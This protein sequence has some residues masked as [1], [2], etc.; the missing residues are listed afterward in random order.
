[1]DSKIIL[2]FAV[3]ACLFFAGCAQQGISPQGPS[4]GNDSGAI[5]T[6]EPGAQPVPGGQPPG[7]EPGT[8]PG[9]LPPINQSPG[10]PFPGP[11]QQMNQSACPPPPAPCLP[12][13]QSPGQPFPGPGQPPNPSPGQQ[14]PSSNTLSPD[15]STPAKGPV[16]QGQ[17]KTFRLGSLQFDYYSVAATY[18]I[19]SP[20]V[21]IIIRAKNTGQAPQTFSLTP[22]SELRTK[23]P[24]WNRHFFA[25]QADSLTLQPGEEKLVHYFASADNGG[26]FDV[27]IGFMQGAAKETASI[28]VYSGSM[29]EARL[30]SSAVIYGT[31]RDGEGKPV[32]YAELAFYPFGG[33]ERYYQRTDA[34]GAYFVSVPGVDDVQTFY[35]GQ[36]LLSNIEY[37]AMMD[38]GGYAHYYKDGIAPK[39]G[40]T[41]E[42]NITLQK[43]SPPKGYAMKWES[44]VSDYY[45]F[46]YAFPD[47]N[48]SVVAAA[49]AK[50]D[51]ALGK[52]TN[53]YLFDAKTGALKWKHPT[54]DDCW[55]FDI[56]N[57]LVAA[58][59]SDG[60]VYV[61][62]TDGTERWEKDC[63]TQNREVELSP[64]GSLL[65]TGPC[66]NDEYEL[67]NAKT[68]ALVSTAKDA[69]EALRRS[70]FSPDGQFFVTGASF[71]NL[72]MYSLDGKQVWK[73]YVGEFPLFLEIDNMGN[74]YASGKGRMIFSYDR[75]GKERWS[76]RVPDHVVSAGAISADGS[77]VVIGTIGAWV[78]VLDGR[79]GQV[80][81]RDR[82]GGEN[83]G[84]NAVSM[85]RDG[86]HVAIGGAPQYG[87][88]IYDEN[89]TR[90]FTHEA[91]ENPD[92]ILN[93]KWAGIGRDAS[94]GT[95][96]GT[97]GTFISDNG[98]KVVAAYGD[99]YVRLFE[100]AG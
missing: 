44:K 67:L 19:Y 75:Q 24:N 56:K 7:K 31:V 81:W 97:M 36:K 96:K 66:G 10:Q 9:S 74:T 41:L 28:S 11:G 92:P 100:R 60:R 12:I 48:W 61:V 29:D 27:N 79:T 17:N 46:F 37:F 76:F 21:D 8:V 54:G 52:P 33:R 62:G 69:R 39:R 86:K 63:Q 43:A 80:L 34:S 95:Q 91:A 3:C 49:Q 77:R 53:F 51:P 99:D 78:Y 64:D 4:G 83:V 70:R 98:D 5:K 50:H 87:L 38:A 71:G 26:Q 18:P 85:S 68:G 72:A 20:G 94:A 73:N 35:G 15:I 23:V 14:G 2:V 59:C 22:I 6:G 32:P 30:A 25:F 16:L 88:Y 42:F 65:L 45:G 82:I 58:G 84:H 40:E 55:G 1:M 93:E 47:E 57:G 13:N 90:I 89:G